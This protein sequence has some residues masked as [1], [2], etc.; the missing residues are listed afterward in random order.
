MPT[1]SQETKYKNNTRRETGHLD[2][3]QQSKP[4]L[5]QVD[6]SLLIKQQPQQQ[7]FSKKTF[8]S[9]VIGQPLTVKSGGI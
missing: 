6:L 5:K 2:S 3:D 1:K 7:P 9:S 4:G 8:I